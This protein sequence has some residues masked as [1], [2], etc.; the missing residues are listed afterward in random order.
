MGFVDW[1]SGITKS[2][3]GGIMILLMYYILVY[4]SSMAITIGT[5]TTIFFVYDSFVHK[6]IDRAAARSSAI[7]LF[8]LVPLLL[9]ATTLLRGLL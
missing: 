6:Q 2:F 1:G 3:N 8:I 4:F 5:L 7:Y 9:L